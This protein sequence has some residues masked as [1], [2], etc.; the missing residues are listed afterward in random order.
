MAAAAVD[1][2]EEGAQDVG[3]RNDKCD[4]ESFF[5]LFFS[6]SNETCSLRSVNWLGFLRIILLRLVIIIMNLRRSW[7]YYIW[8]ISTSCLHSCVTTSIVYPFLVSGSEASRHKTYL[9]VY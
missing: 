8:F 4:D 9:H 5:L 7:F 3:R 6:F 2:M 1:D